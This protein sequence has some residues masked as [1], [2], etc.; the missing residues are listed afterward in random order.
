LACSSKCHAKE[1]VCCNNV[2]EAPNA[3]SESPIENNEATI[4]KG[5]FDKLIETQ[6]GKKR[7]RPAKQNSINNNNIE[8]VENVERLKQ[9]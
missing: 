1:F 2:D 7:K 5:D 9:G 8:I 4:E 6:V 3:N